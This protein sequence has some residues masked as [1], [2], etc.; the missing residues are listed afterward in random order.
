MP[1]LSITDRFICGDGVSVLSHL[2]QESIDCVVTSPP[3]WQLRDF[4]VKGQLGLEATLDDYTAKLC[5]VFDE[6]RRALKDTGTLWVN[7]GDTY[8]GKRARLPAKCLLQ[9]PARFAIEMTSTLR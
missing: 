9:V 8:S 7:L 5:A 2:P 1:K 6:V 4:G 3:Y